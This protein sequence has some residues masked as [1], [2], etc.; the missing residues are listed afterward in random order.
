MHALFTCIVYCAQD[1][2]LTGIAVFRIPDRRY[3]GVAGDRGYGYWWN[4][5]SWPYNTITDGE[6]VTQEAL[7]DILG[8]F[9]YLKNSGDHPE[10]ANMA[11][12]WVGAVGCK[13]EGRRF[14][15]QY[16]PTFLLSCV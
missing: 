6:N 14:I 12:T 1:Y 2:R 15:G 3:R 9:D 10:S 5:I 11:L 13:R 8:I 16:L 4:E 7:A